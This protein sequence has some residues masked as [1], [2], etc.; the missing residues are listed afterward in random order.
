MFGNK[1]DSQLTSPLDQVQ[2]F[3]GVIELTDDIAKTVVGGKTTQ[4]NQKGKKKS[5]SLLQKYFNFTKGF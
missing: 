1:I 4:A 3:N 5:K 2:N